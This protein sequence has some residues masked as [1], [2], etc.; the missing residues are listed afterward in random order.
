VSGDNP[1]TCTY[2]NAATPAGD[3][4]NVQ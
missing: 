1:I 2:G 4:I 3:V